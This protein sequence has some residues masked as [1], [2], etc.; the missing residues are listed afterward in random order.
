MPK[1]KIID[2]FLDPDYYQ[3]IVSHFLGDVD[4]PNVQWNY[5]RDM[6]GNKHSVIKKYT[7][8]EEPVGISYQGFSHPV[9]QANHQYSPYYRVLLPMIEKIRRLLE[10]TYCYRIMAYMT[11]Q[12]ESK[13]NFG[14]HVDMPGT[15]HNSAIFYLNDSDGDTCLYNEENPLD[16]VEEVIPKSLTL[17][18]RVQPKANRL[19]CFE[20]NYWHSSY[21]PVVSPRRII[22]NMNFGNTKIPDQG[23]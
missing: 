5:E 17:A 14:H 22:F 4:I 8:K 18:E 9:W 1:Y 23:Y 13:R 20:G 7:G 3:L 11:L 2:N 19:L 6:S 12:T 10:N 15:K 16:N 21:S